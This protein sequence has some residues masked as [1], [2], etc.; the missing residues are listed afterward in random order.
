MASELADLYPGE[1]LLWTGMPTRYPVLSRTDRVILPLSAFAVIMFVSNAIVP[2]IRD[3]RA[4]N[5]VMVPFL[6]VFGLMVTHLLAGRFVV[7][8]RELRTTTYTVTDQRVIV[9]SRPLLG[10]RVNSAYLRALLPPLVVSESGSV[11][12]IKFGQATL[13]QEL[14]RE[15]NRTRRMEF[16][17][18]LIEIDNVWQVRDT[19]ARAQRELPPY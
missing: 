16:V 15:G 2:M 18:E 8:R 1:R 5:V 10:R 6:V 9:V 13:F 7:R 3:D 14:M 12:T 11:G 17:P 4:G 19:I